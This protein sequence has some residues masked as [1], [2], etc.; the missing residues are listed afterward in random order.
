[1]YFT[2]G[3]QWFISRITII[4]QSS[5]SGGPTFSR[6]VKLFPDG[7]QLLIPMETCKTCD[8]PRGVSEPTIFPFGS[9]HEVA[10]VSDIKPLGFSVLRY[11]AS[12]LHVLMSALSHS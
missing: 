8:F 2:E 4:F 10:R 9:G 11:N 5:R 1:M 12:K 6:G 7:D 3:V